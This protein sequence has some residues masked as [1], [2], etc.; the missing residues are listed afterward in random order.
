M[1]RRV[2]LAFRQEMKFRNKLVDYITEWVLHASTEIEEVAPE[3][4]AISWFV[5]RI[6]VYSFLLM[7]ALLTCSL[8]YV[9][10]VFYLS[11]LIWWMKEVKVIETFL[12]LLFKEQCRARY[13]G[14]AVYA[15][16]V[17]NRTVLCGNSEFHA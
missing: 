2:D 5:N 8:V 10:I 12:S 9:D 6:H 17:K 4:L 3:I 1:A 11:V 16:C 14:R 7:Y 13:L 15:I